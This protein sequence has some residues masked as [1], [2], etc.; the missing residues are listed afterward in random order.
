MKEFWAR[1]NSTERRFVVGVGVVFFLVINIVWIRPHFGDWSATRNR[2][3]VAKRQLVTFETGTNLIPE[4]VKQRDKLMGQGQVV[5]EENQTLDFSRLVMNQLT[6]FG[7]VP[8]NTSYRRESG[9]T[10]SFFLEQSATMSLDTTEK[11]LVDFLYSVGAGSNSLIRVKAL[12]I[13]PEPQ[14]T[15]LNTRLTLV[16]SYEK[17]AI[18]AAPA[19]GVKPAGTSQKPPVAPNNARPGPGAAPNNAKT[20][21]TGPSH[22]TVTSTNR[23]TRAITNRIGGPAKSLT[24]NKK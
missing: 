15:R 17:K 6:M 3:E 18:V 9:P 1:L 20:P 8:Q 13:Q 23:P 24:P 14:H 4:L 21:G 22:V 7:I 12:S 10:N 2:M 11:Q 16:A 5:P 19:A